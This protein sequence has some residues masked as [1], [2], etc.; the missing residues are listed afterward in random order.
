MAQQPPKTF[1]PKPPDS[2]RANILKY[3]SEKK[4]WKLQENV[5]FADTALPEVC[6]IFLESGQGAKWYQDSKPEERMDILRPFDAPD[7]LSNKTCTELNGYFGSKSSYS[8]GKNNE[9]L[10]ALST[11]FRILTKRVLVVGNNKLDEPLTFDKKDYRWY[12]MGIF[13]YWKDAEICRVLCIDTPPKMCT[14]LCK[15]LNGPNDPNDPRNF[16][17]ELRDPFST[18]LPLLDEIV[19]LCDDNTWRATRKVREIEKNRKKRPDFEELRNLAR[20]TGHLVEV[21]E[22]AVDTLERLA[23][24]Q[25][26]KC[27]EDLQDKLTRTHIIRAQEYL[28][29]QLT[30]LRGLRMRASSTHE[31]LQEEIN[32]VGYNL[33]PRFSAGS[34]EIT[35]SIQRYNMLASSDNTIMKSITLLTMIFLPSTFVTS[36]FSTTFFAFQDNEWQ[37]S[38]KFWIYWVIVIPLTLVVVL[39]WKWWIVGGEHVRWKWLTKKQAQEADSVPASFARAVTFRIDKLKELRQSQSQRSQV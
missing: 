1:I 2:P 14:Q 24:C 21:H 22:V 13:T 29:F 37:F 34:L 10:T 3:D 39:F 31:R 4:T 19:K 32:L 12:E 11:W 33:D 16:T 23:R 8:D 36:L 38:N 26:K 15:F 30:T 17:L 28:E 7:F 6:Y 18:L 20:H 5:I 35:A 9:S 27:K 25:E